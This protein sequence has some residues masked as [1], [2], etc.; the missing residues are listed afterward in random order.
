MQSEFISLH[1]VIATLVVLVA[2]GAVAQQDPKDIIA[3]QLRAQGLCMRPSDECD[4]RFRR[5]K[6]Q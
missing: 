3:A 6:T 1:V 4:T 5:V 2:G